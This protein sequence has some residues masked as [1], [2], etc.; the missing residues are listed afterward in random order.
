MYID[1]WP[2][3]GV[4]GRNPERE[5]KGTKDRKMETKKSIF[6]HIDR[7]VLFMD[8]YTGKVIFLIMAII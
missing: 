4:S 2:F 3:P 5:G 1:A 8:T 7:C 6:S